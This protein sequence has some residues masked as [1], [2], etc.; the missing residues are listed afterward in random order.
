[1]LSKG[2]NHRRAGNSTPWQGDSL[3]DCVAGG[4]SART[5][6]R[7]VVPFL[8][9]QRHRVTPAPWLAGLMQSVARRR[10]RFRRVPE[11][12]VHVGSPGTELF[13]TLEVTKS[14]PLNKRLRRNAAR[15]LRHRGYQ[16]RIEAERGW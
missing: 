14:Q 15:Q 8:G 13:L 3:Y 5:T 4:P 7:K 1:M 16:V 9:G 12:S 2:N 6:G 11:D 10:L